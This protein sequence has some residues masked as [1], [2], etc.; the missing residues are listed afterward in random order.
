MLRT[1]SKTAAKRSAKG[2]AREGSLS[3]LGRKLKAGDRVRIV[4][5][6]EA[7]KNEDYDLKHSE[8]GNM[9]TAELFRF[10]VGREFTIEAFDEYGHVE[11][12]AADENSAVRKEFGKWH[13]IWSEP[14][15][16]EHVTGSKVGSR[17]R[18]T[19]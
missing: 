11:I 5:I 19:N 2:A 8:H 18:K 7:L 14:E 10:C 4:D 13:T 12:R 17:K 15:F 6:S 3:R 9:R 16:V 1:K